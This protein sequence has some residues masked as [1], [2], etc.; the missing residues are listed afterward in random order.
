MLCSEIGG[1]T[2]TYVQLWIHL[3]EIESDDVRM[4]S[5][6]GQGVAKLGIGHAVRFG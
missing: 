5:Q 6:C 4:L 3:N 1:E 2:G